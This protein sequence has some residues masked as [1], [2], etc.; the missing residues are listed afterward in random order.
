MNAWL[1]LASVAG[2]LYLFWIVL[3]FTFRLIDR[4]HERLREEARESGSNPVGEMDG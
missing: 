4:A 2:M 1:L 3:S